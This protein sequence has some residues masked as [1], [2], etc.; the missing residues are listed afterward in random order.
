MIQ[1]HSIIIV[2][3]CLSISKSK[4]NSVISLEFVYCADAGVLQ[5]HADGPDNITRNE[6]EENIQVD[7]PLSL[8]GAPIWRINNSLLDLASIELP[9]IP[10]RFGITI[11]LVTRNIDQTKFQCFAP[12]G[13]GLHVRASDVGTLTVIKQAR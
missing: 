13:N 8:T 3:L 9:L 6:G 11:T 4:N 5:V 12:T 1:K 2:H 7:C 10:T